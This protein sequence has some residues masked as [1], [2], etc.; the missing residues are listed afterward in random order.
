M[1][2]KRLL[3]LGGYPATYMRDLHKELDKDPKIEIRYIFFKFKKGQILE[4]S[5]ERGSISKNALVFTRNNKKICN[6]IIKE[7]YIDKN[8]GIIF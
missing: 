1:K 5:Y 6:K 2:I 7:H 4:R 8:T 3:W